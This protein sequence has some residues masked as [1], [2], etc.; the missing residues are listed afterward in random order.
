VRKRALLAAVLSIGAYGALSHWLMLHAANQ[1]WAVA[2]IMGPM[3]LGF[4]VAAWQRRHLPSLLLC[5]VAVV[6]LGVVTALGGVDDV[7]RL[8][9]LQYVGIN[10]ALCATFAFTLRRG[11]TPLLA[12]IAARV[13]RDFPPPMRAYAGRLTRAWVAYFALMSLACLVL[14]AWAPWSWWSLFANLLTPV[15]VLGFLL[16]EHMLR[17]RMHPEFE[18]ATVMEALLAYRKSPASEGGR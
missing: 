3:V 1:P 13:H 18:R 11:S 16:G 17:Y 14:Y 5:S 6:A 8:Y 7:H 12:R 4:A 15:A 9:V 10:L 2:A